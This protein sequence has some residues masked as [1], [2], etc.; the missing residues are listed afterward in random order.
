M[1]V[2]EASHFVLRFK[3]IPLRGK[4]GKKIDMNMIQ[5]PLYTFLLYYYLED[6]SSLPYYDE[7]ME[8]P[9]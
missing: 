1:T 2:F 6:L 8:S 7:I 5:E 3:K 4:G 9:N